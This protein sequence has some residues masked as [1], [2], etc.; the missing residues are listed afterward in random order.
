MSYLQV[1]L[2]FPCDYF[3]KKQVEDDYKEEYQQGVQ[4]GFHVILFDYD[5][6]LQ[7]NTVNIYHNND[8]QGI[9]IY[10]GW[11]LKPKHYE[12]LYQF[13]R[14]QGLML[15]NNPTEYENCHLFQNSYPLLTNLTP[16]TK[17]YEFPE[18]ID[19]D[20]I[21]SSFH[22]FMIK[23]FVKSVKGHD[24]PAFFDSSYTNEELHR[25]IK[26]FQELR[27][28]LYTGGIVIKEFVE[29]AVE[30]GKTNEY[31]AF[32]LY[33]N[34]ISLS[35]N[36]NQS[37]LSP[38]VPKDFLLSVPKMNSNFYTVD[39]AQRNNGDWFVIETGD[40]QV[41]GLSPNQFAFKFYEEI[42]EILGERE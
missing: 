38:C 14:N 22:R 21:K 35:K 28:N 16:Q 20:F 42:A 23:D 37:Q 7:E 29:I 18:E 15:I 31:R 24:F 25:Y 40:G 19:W 34:L 8:F 13:L 1:T 11:M 9:C 32:Y 12:I 5:K 39:F 10:R 41:S 26:K 3:D 30:E 27:G 33:D 17:F 2:L 6:F 4:Q 36:S